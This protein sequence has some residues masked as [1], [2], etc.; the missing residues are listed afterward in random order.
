V[1]IGAGRTETGADG[2]RKTPGVVGT[3]RLGSAA[4]ALSVT[5]GAGGAT[6]M[7]GATWSLLASGGSVTAVDETRDEVGHGEGVLTRG[8]ACGSEARGS[9][10]GGCG[11][12]GRP[13][14]MTGLDDGVALS[15]PLELGD[16][17]R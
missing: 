16:G 2:A 7:R 3:R 4:A 13:D 8:G 9:G 15:A 1:D 5:T 10:G 14:C 11:A 6:G 12:D 17:G